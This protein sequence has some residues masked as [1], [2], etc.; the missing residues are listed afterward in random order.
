ML[1]CRNSNPPRCL[2]MHNFRRK[3]LYTYLG[4]TPEVGIYINFMHTVHWLKQCP[5]FSKFCRQNLSRPTPLLH[6]QKWL[7]TLLDAFK[8]I[9]IIRILRKLKK[10]IML[11]PYVRSLR[12][13]ILCDSAHNSKE[14]Q[15]YTYLTYNSSPSRFHVLWFLCNIRSNFT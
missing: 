5:S 9:V 3:Q 13:H 14:N 12:F 4:A 2:G 10:I 15:P 8:S 1:A 11:W 7:R 6:F